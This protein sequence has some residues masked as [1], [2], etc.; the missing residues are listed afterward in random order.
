MHKQYKSTH[1][2]FL[3]RSMSKFNPF[4]TPSLDFQSASSTLYGAA[5]AGKKP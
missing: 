2:D 3:S 5:G 4:A 1:N